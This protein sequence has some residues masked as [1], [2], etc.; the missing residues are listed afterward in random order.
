M[1]NIKNRNIKINWKLMTIIL[2]AIEDKFSHINKS[3]FEIIEIEL[4]NSGTYTFQKN[5][6]LEIGFDFIV[7]V[8]Y[9]DSKYNY[10]ETWSCVLEDSEWELL[11]SRQEII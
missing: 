4:V 11:K 2:M 6:N 9:W 8:K 5:T 7:E 1:N 3:D 10:F